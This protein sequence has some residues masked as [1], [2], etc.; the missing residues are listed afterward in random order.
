V[1][2]HFSVD[3]T[4]APQGSKRHVG[5]G[6]MVE[7][8]KEA[9]PWRDLIAWHAKQAIGE[10]GWEPIYG[11]VHVE[12][13]FRFARPASHYGTGKN[14]SKLKRSAPDYKFSTPDL[15][16]LVRNVLDALVTA[17]VF[18]NDGQVAVLVADKRYAERPGLRVRVRPL[19]LRESRE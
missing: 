9:R 11:P 14:Q 1:V 10:Q 15:D 13:L 2:L 19:D 7:M 8:A 18:R 5:G 3:G 16:K 4:P 12:L 17:G 6:V